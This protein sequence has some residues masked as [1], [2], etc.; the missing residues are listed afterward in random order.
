MGNR[1]NIQPL[2]HGIGLRAPHYQDLLQE[3]HPIDFLEIISEGFML[4][5]GKP[6]TVLEALLEKY[7]MV[8]HGVSLSIGSADPLDK[9]YLKR[10]KTLANKVRPPWFSDHIC[11]T[12]VHGRNLHNLMPLPYTQSTIDYVSERIKIVQDYMEIP[13]I[14]ENVSSY[15]EFDASQME[16]WEFVARVAEQADC[17]ILLDVNN[18]FVSGFNHEFDPMTYINAIPHDR[19]LQY[20]VAGHLDKGSFILDTH[21]HDIRSEVWDL[22]EKTIPLFSGVSTLIERDDNLPPLQDVLKELNIARK[23]NQR[24]TKAA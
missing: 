12:K 11:W 5:G 9:N 18:I 21:D 2:G 20:H 24:L 6:I 14:F 15:V 10:L 7:P 13:F 3:S 17:G 8:M 19:V 23:I 1:F 4:D 22:Y 16:E